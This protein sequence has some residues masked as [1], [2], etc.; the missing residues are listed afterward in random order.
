MDCTQRPS[1]RGSD[2]VCE[3]TWRGN[4]RRSSRADA[5]VYGDLGD[6]DHNQGNTAPEE[7]LFI[8]GWLRQDLRLGLEHTTGIASGKRPIMRPLNGY[9]WLRCRHGTGAIPIVIRNIQT[10]ECLRDRSCAGLASFLLRR[11]R[12]GDKPFDARAATPR[13]EPE[14][15]AVERDQFAQGRPA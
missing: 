12:R 5:V 10:Q 4:H 6:G 3:A 15:R 2:R 14:F 7:A 13:R 1:P 9:E 11:W 8:Q